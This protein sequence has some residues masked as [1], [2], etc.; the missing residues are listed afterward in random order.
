MAGSI[1]G[2]VGKGVRN[3]ERTKLIKSAYDPN[4]TLEQNRKTVGDRAT[5]IAESTN[6]RTYFD[7]ANYVRSLLGLSNVPAGSRAATWASQTSGQTSGQS[8]DWRNSSRRATAATSGSGAGSSSDRS[9]GTRRHEWREGGYNAIYQEPDNSDRSTPPGGGMAAQVGWESPQS[10]GESLLSSDGGAT[11]DAILDMDTGSGGDGTGSGEGKND[12]RDIAEFMFDWAPIDEQLTYIPEAY[13][14]EGNLAF[15]VN[16]NVIDEDSLE[17]QLAAR[18]MFSDPEL[19]AKYGDN[20]GAWLYSG[21]KEM[22]RNLFDSDLGRMGWEWIMTDPQYWR[23]A[24]SGWDFDYYWD[25]YV[26]PTGARAMGNLIDMYD[27]MSMG[28]IADLGTILYY[29]GGDAR[30]LESGLEYLLGLK[31]YQDYAPQLN[32]NDMYQVDENGDLMTDEDGNYYFRD[33]I[34]ANMYDDSGVFAGQLTGGEDAM[35]RMSPE[36]GPVM[37]NYS[38]DETVNALLNLSAGALSNAA[39]QANERPS[40]YLQDYD[41]QFLGGDDYE[42]RVGDVGDLSASGYVEVPYKNYDPYTSLAQ[43]YDEEGNLAINPGA[44]NYSSFTA[45]GDTLAGSPTS[46]V[47]ALILAGNYATRYD[48]N[49]EPIYPSD[50]IGQYYTSRPGE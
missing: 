5:Q 26:D 20:W 29:A 17:Q 21:D 23:D 11:A 49:N 37:N 35:F 18:I 14:E 38:T 13:D 6:D 7:A 45:E 4:A 3:D 24:N 12:V 22:W 36:F 8:S 10:D 48:D 34:A 19:Y 28:N 44:V 9:S 41:L 15:T 30:L 33:D 50:R 2:N 16:G 40:E 39:I 47:P 31:D 32:L 25:T 43:A 42:Y 46:Y 1:I 27:D